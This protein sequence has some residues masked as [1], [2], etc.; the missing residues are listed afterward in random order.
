MPSQLVTSHLRASVVLVDVAVWDNGWGKRMHI[1]GLVWG[2]NGRFTH[3]P[4]T[5]CNVSRWGCPDM[6]CL[7]SKTIRPPV[8]AFGPLTCFNSHQ[9]GWG[10]TSRE[11]S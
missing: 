3:T 9:L 2:A 8:N 10:K 7:V 6:T 4:E 5:V 1:L 11:V